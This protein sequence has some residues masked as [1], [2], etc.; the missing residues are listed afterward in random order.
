MEDQNICKDSWSWW[1]S[2]GKGNM[3]IVFF[4]LEYFKIFLVIFMNRDGIGCI[5]QFGG[6]KVTT[7][8]DKV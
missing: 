7:L 8:S 5:F 1:K 3:L 2:I 4:F 6:P